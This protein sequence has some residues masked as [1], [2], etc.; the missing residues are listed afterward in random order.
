MEF[1]AS[2]GQLHMILEWIRQ[3]LKPMDFSPKVL[4]RI[5]LAS[6]EA[7]VNTIQHA[8]QG[9][10]EK[11]E[12]K[13]ELFKTKA[14]ISFIDHGAPFN[15]VNAKSIDQ[16]LPLEEREIGGLG[17]HFIRRCVDEMH[18]SYTEQKNVLTFIIHS[19]QKK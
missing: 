2:L 5:E 16:D 10:P 18:Y 15:P 11:V 14:E 4:H 9:R 8:Y 7:L 17:I 6:E 19:S 1:T 12:I 13:V 3:Q